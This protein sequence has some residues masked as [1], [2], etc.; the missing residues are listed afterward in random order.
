MRTIKK[1]LGCFS[2]GELAL[3][4]FSTGILLL[5]F[6][7]FDRG[8]WTTLAASV[9]GV[10]SLLFCAKGN[11]LGPILL[12]V[13]SLLYGI[14]SFTFRYYGEMITY[15]GMSAPM[16]VVTLIAW[17]RNPFHGNR[18]EVTVYRVKAKEMAAAFLLSAVVTLVFYFL[19][20]ALHTA[21]LLPSTL[22]VTT[23]F[24]AVYLT[25][26]RSPY[27]AL[28]YAANDGI[29]VVLWVLAA[30]DDRSYLPVAVCFLLFLINDLYGFVNWRK[31]E[32][33]QRCAGLPSPD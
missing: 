20:E 7:L 9:I 25:F 29:L 24:L 3:W 11:P 2:R 13:F 33:R 31:M 26:R 15:L 5:T 19:L 4:G 28:A 27:Y 17:L 6:L 21:N 23:T 18:A 16:A 14:I 22:S 32:K 12:I 1:L 10:T 8:N 30:M